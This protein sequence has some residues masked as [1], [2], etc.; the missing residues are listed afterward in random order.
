MAEAERRML[1]QGVQGGTTAGHSIDR[2]L[3]RNRST[4]PAPNRSIVD[5][6]PHLPYAWSQ[7][8]AQMNVGAPGRDSA[9]DAQTSAAIA[10]SRMESQ[11]THSEEDQMRKAIEESRR[12]YAT[13]QQGNVSHVS[14]Q[15]SSTEGYWVSLEPRTGR[16]VDFY[17]DEVQDILNRSAL[18]SNVFLGAACFSATIYLSTDGKHYQTTPAIAGAK[19]KPAGYRSVMRISPTT[20]ELPVWKFP[21]GWRLYPPLQER[22]NMPVETGIATVPAKEETQ[23][24]WEWCRS[25][26]I[27]NATEAD[28]ISYSD[29]VQQEL[30]GR[31]TQGGSFN[32]FVD[33]GVRQLEIEV[34]IREA[35]YKQHDRTARKVRWVRRVRRAPSILEAQH[36]SLTNGMLDDVCPICQEDFSETSHMPR[37]T[38]SCSHQFHHLC[39]QPVLER[40]S[41]AKC[42]ICRSCIASSSDSSQS[43][44]NR[45]R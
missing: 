31:F 45:Y 15:Q 3:A 18:G 10:Q 22:G 5:V 7:E 16:Y 34:D 37:Q 27:A 19:G 8:F 29:M 43:S 6:P 39:L 28:W 35:Y 17:S 41:N 44:R 2:E 11:Q 38:L 1:A 4:E 42:P 32:H 12:T 30:E 26:S 20:R 13:P 9:L 33:I 36:A 23:V 24:V 14:Q 21:P 25:N 40:N